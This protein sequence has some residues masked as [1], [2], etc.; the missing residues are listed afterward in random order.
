[1]KEIKAPY[2]VKE[3]A[4]ASGVSPDTVRFYTKERLLKPKRDKKNQYNLYGH[5]DLVRL[6][7]ILRA[8]TLGYTISEIKKILKASEKGESP[9]SFVRDILAKRIRQ[10]KQLLEDSLALQKRIEDAMKK[11]QR[12]PDGIPVGDSICFLI[13]SVTR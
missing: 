10:N 6:R 2:H 7:F 4:D 8:K 13:E 1:M 5:S 11:W 3:L 9:C 12:L